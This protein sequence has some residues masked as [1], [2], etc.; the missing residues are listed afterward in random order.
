MVMKNFHEMSD[1]ELGQS[2]QLGAMELYRR[3]R[4]ADEAAEAAGTEAP[5]AIGWAGDVFTAGGYEIHATS[6]DA[7]AGTEPETD[8]ARERR[9]RLER[10]GVPPSDQALAQAEQA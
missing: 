6:D 4:L 1:T 10:D 2:L 7:L 8:E 5:E 9:E 3:R